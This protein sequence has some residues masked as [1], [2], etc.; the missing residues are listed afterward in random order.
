M[1]KLTDEERAIWQWQIW[2]RDF[3]EA[4]QEK[5]KNSSVLI[6]RCGGV[7]GAVAYEL[8]A[9][10]VGRLVIAHR[11]NIKPSDLN[12]QLLTT[13]D[14]VGTLRIE[15]IERRL[16]Q[17][18]PRMGIVAVNENVDE[19]NAASLVEQ[20]DLVVDCAPLFEERFAMND[21]AVRQGKPLVECAMYDLQCQITTILPGQTACLRCLY[22]RFPTEWKREFPVFGAVA[23]TVGCMGAM[24]AI[25]VIA[26]LGEPLAD[27][28]LTFD[29]RDFSFR[30][31]SLQ[32]DPKCVCCG[33]ATGNRTHP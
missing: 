9:A 1:P 7:G 10:G 24:E 30:T 28:L 31:I 32:R 12:R 11:G 4:G 25:K 22:P 18:N 15:S 13:H 27:R 33:K 19:N 17:L 20:V 23:G 5:L 6:S 14:A 2:V 26:G 29:L 8:A 16:K 21:Q 3:G